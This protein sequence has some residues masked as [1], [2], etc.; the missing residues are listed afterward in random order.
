MLNT[1]WNIWDIILADG[2]A[3]DPSKTAAMLKWPKPTTVTELRGFLGLTGYYRKFVRNYGIIAKPL[4]QLLKKKNFGW[5]DQADKAFITLKSAMMCTP[6][7]ALP[8]F[9][10]P[11][12]I[13]TDAC[14][15]G[16][17]AV[18]MQ[19]GQPIAFLSKA[20]GDKHKHLS[21]YEKEFL[22][23]IMAVERWRPY[24]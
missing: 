9:T 16:I 8:N 3:T 2:V 14:G 10:E 11:F 7:L 22:A 23:L 18:L 21:L 17:G 4:T 20:L 12:T 24:L 5:N 6:V 1:A 13:E 19:K 15:D